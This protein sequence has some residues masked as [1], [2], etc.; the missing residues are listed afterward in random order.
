MQQLLLFSSR[1]LSDTD[2][3]EDTVLE[4]DQA[5]MLWL[6]LESDDEEVYLCRPETK[7][8]AE[9]MQLLTGDGGLKKASVV[10]A[11]IYHIRGIEDKECKEM[12]KVAFHGEVYVNVPAKTDDTR[13]HSIRVS[14]SDKNSLYSDAF[15]YATL[16]IQKR[17]DEYVWTEQKTD[18]CVTAD[19][20]VTYTIKARLFDLSEKTLDV[21]TRHWTMPEFN[22]YYGKNKLGHTAS[23]STVVKESQ[24]I[25][26]LDKPDDL[27]RKIIA[28]P[29]GAQVK[30]AYT[31][32]HEREGKFSG[33]AMPKCDAV[34]SPSLYD[35][36]QL[37]IPFACNIHDCADV[38]SVTTDSVS[39]RVNVTAKLVDQAGRVL[40]QSK[41]KSGYVCV[42][43]DGIAGCDY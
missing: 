28:P 37:M 31:F 10:E 24:A 16:F 22:M 35:T 32:F 6:Y 11:Q 19:A 3:D 29:E 14:S 18:A 27:I 1:A 26:R 17:N 15:E 43:H 12:D 34:T 8:L 5:L 41:Q 40:A 42:D 7:V 21:Q 9:A 4:P 36:D 39:C 38:N 20:P 23:D 25:I 13:L 33:K 2:I 30:Y